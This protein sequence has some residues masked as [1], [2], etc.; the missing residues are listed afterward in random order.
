MSARTSPTPRA[1]KAREFLTFWKWNLA[2]WGGFGISSFL[3]RLWFHQDIFRAFA[4]TLL[5][6]GT[7]ILLSLALRQ[8]YR[9]SPQVFQIRSALILILGSLG[10]TLVQSLISTAFTLLTEWHNP[11]LDL[12]ILFF[13]RTLVMWLLFMLWSL[14]Y[15]WF[16]T[17]LEREEE[18]I[19]RAAA[20]Q[21]ARRMELQMLRA[22][23]DPHFLFNSLN[24]IAAEIRPH[25]QSAA[26]MVNELSDYLR[27]SLDHRK[28]SLGRLSAEIDA[29]QAYLKIEFARFGDKL[30]FTVDAP[31]E[32]RMAKVPAFLLQPLVENAIKHGLY[33][34]KNRMLLNIRAEVQADLLQIL[35]SNSG[36]LR[37]RD[38]SSHGLGLDTLRRRLDLHY[39]DRYKF[40]IFQDGNFV[41]AA[42]TLKGEPC[43]G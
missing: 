25:P 40:E 41:R 9:N 38:P 23:L 3:V 43:C 5:I 13:L 2:V 15:F 29:M 18:G 11:L 8:V 39:P 34:A 33:R 10:A 22:Q 19:L 31:P 6:E 17:D 4:F 1:K 28:N 7:G 26:R 42:L 37:P 21:E 20:Q 24:G 14:G 36:T 16:R 32:A 12:P 27:Y 30:A 35:V